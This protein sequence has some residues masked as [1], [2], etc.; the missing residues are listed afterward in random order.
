[1]NAITRSEYVSPREVLELKDVDMPVIKDDEVLVR[2]HA[3]RVNA[4]DPG[5]VRGTPYTAL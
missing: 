1:M 2:V 3:A 4:A 5:V